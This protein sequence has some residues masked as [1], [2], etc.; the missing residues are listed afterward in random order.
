MKAAFFEDDELTA[1]LLAGGT[2]SANRDLPDVVKWVDLMSF[3]S[4]VLPI[5]RSRLDA[6]TA[7]GATQQFPIPKEGAGSQRSVT[8]SDPYDELIYRCLTGRIVTAIDNTLGDEVKSYRLSSP[9][10]GWRFRHYRYGDG[11]RREDGLRF[12]ESGMF[13]AFGVM[14]VRQYYPSIS[15]AG[16]AAVLDRIGAPS[17]DVTALVTYLQDWVEV[18]GRTGAS[19]RLRVFWGS[20]KRHAGAA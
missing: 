7:P 9:A 6:S 3:P 15:I 14:D 17:C 8:I 11:E 1:S 5:L 12:I 16:L 19:H 18:W 20:G 4:E 2:W 10:P 13:G